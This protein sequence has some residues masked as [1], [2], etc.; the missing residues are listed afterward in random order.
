[1]GEGRV[2]AVALSPGHTFSKPV[3]EQITLVEGVGVE[4]DAHAGKRVKHRSRVRVDPTQPNLRQIHLIHGE[5]HD[6]LVENGFKVGPGIMGENI[7]TRGLDLLG[8]PRGTKLHIGTDAIVEVTGLRNP[9]QQ[10]N[11]YQDGLTQAVLDRTPD[12][13]LIRKAGIMGIVLKGGDVCVADTIRA[14]FP[15]EP[16]QTLERV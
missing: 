3:C 12:G 9:C 8:L 13:A 2:V 4:G 15:P 11:D 10:L 14:E 16:Y 7:T 6:E 5:L 1:M